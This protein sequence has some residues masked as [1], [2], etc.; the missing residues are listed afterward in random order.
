MKKMSRTEQTMFFADYERSRGNYIADV[1]GNVMLD[2]YQQIASIPIG[3]NHPALL[4]MTD[5]PYFKTM[6]VNRHALGFMPHSNHMNTLDDTLLRVKPKGLDNVQMAM[7]G[8]CA[9]ETAM[10]CVFIR[11]RSMQ[12]GSTE[13]TE[14]E[15][16][17]TLEGKTPGCPNLCIIG[18]TKGFHGRTIGCLTVTHS[19]EIHKV[20]IPS[21]PW[22]VARWP[23]LKYPLHQYV[24][25]N[26]EEEA[27]CLE[28]LY[29][30]IKATNEAG[31]HAAGVILEPI[32][33]EGGD[34]YAS[35]AFF[36]GVQKIAHEF[37]AAFMVDEVQTGGGSTG[38]MWAHEHWD[39]PTAP[40]TV[41]FAKKM[42]VGGYYFKDE[43]LSPHPYRIQNTWMGD[44]MRVYLLKAV[45]D[46]IEKDNLLGRVVEAGDVLDVALQDMEAEFPDVVHSNRGIGTFRAITFHNQ[47]A[48]NMTMMACRNMGLNCGPC[49]DMAIRF[50]P[51][52]IYTPDHV[53]IT[54]NI[55]RA[56]LVAVRDSMRVEATA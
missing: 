39:L 21:F 45:L 49:G 34:N 54:M 14:E 56:A 30:T 38:K 1:D 10:K 42:L 47:D 8:S 9:V 29:N 28:I 5:D 35:P 31:V 2:V 20:D 50:R 23:E 19:K 6:A 43:Y 40:D 25:E 26:E 16:A 46:T 15:M 37:N 53:P 36:R 32:Q 22:P 52:L 17:T 27:R 24:Q 48:R 51:A 12:R 55:F 41:S 18:F 13:P 44:P 7:C 3:Y 4:A 11:Y 33:A